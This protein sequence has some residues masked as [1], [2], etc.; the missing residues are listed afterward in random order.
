MV[1]DEP[2]ETGGPELRLLAGVRHQ[3]AEP[4]AVTVD[5]LRHVVLNATLH[6]ARPA[7]RNHRPWRI[8][9]PVAT[10]AFVVVAA[11]LGAGVL[12]TGHPA[13]RP[14]S[15]PTA[16]TG[17][18]G[19]PLVG[20]GADA[21]R[22]MTLAAQTTQT[23]PSLTAGPGQYIY[24]QTRSTD[25]GFYTLPAGTVNVFA[26][27]QRQDWLDPGKG[28]A[29]VRYISTRRILG[30]VTAQDTAL[31]AKVGFD[32]HPAAKTT[33]SAH[34]DPSGKGEATPPPAAPG[35]RN[36]T[37]QYLNSLPTDPAKLLAVI[38]Q[39]AKSE[40]NTKTSTDATAFDMVGD[41]IVWGDPILSP[42]LRAALYRAVALIPGVSRAPGTV[43]LDNGGKG[44]AVS[45][46]EGNTRDEIIFDPTSLHPLG[47]RDIALKAADGVPAGT[48]LSVTYFV[49]GIVDAVGKT[50]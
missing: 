2:S 38:R 25:V 46:G 11:V 13:R 43:E 35:M 47:T 6:G 28:L 40:G 16:G 42:Q 19:S 48:V 1:N 32:L 8:A 14:A 15:Q 24:R 45:L 4:D 26:S 23:T 31:A 41:L 30:P 20:D 50:G 22:V 7:R 39:E 44:V 3:Y 12:R 10:T 37:P 21:T 9:I 18:H 36:P 33:D 34:P 49:F 17:A 5:R 27:Q 29:D